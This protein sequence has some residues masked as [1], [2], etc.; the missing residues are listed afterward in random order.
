MEAVD[1]SGRRGIIVPM[2]DKI[3]ALIT[4][5]IEKDKQAGLP[6][7]LNRIIWRQR[8]KRMLPEIHR[9]WMFILD[10]KSLAGLLFYH[11]KDNGNK[12]YIDELMV[13]WPYRHNKL[14][15][16]LMLD[17]FQFDREVK[18][19]REIYA[20]ERVRM[21]P[22][23]EILATAGFKETYEGGYHLLGSLPE[24]VEALKIRYIR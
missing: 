17:K 15:F 10:G 2:M 18:A 11:F 20:G 12:L 5:N 6:P 4:E 8:F 23:K 1:Y 3:Y 9:R 7:P 16:P 14:V 24:T 22:D 19:C 13:A 21:E